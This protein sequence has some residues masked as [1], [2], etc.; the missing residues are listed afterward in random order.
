LRIPLFAFGMEARRKSH[1]QPG[2]E[3]LGK[4]VGFEPARAITNACRIVERSLDRRCELL[5]ILGIDQ[6]SKGAI[7]QSVPTPVFASSDHADASS[8][9][10]KK[11]D[12]EAFTH[13]RHHEHIRKPEIVW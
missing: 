7:A 4:E 3:M 12:A 8:H 2:V 5:V 1:L 9:R 13:A 11:D 10:L 6:N